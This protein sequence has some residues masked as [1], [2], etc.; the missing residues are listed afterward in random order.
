MRGNAG[1]TNDRLQRHLNNELAPT[2]HATG[3]YWRNTTQHRTVPHQRNP[4]PW[5]AGMSPQ[6]NSTPD[7]PYK[8]QPAN[9]PYNNPST[10][11]QLATNPPYGNPS[12][13]DPPPNYPPPTYMTPSGPWITTGTGQQAY[14]AGP[15][16]RLGARILDALI[17]GAVAFVVLLAGAVAAGSTGSDVLFFLTLAAVLVGLIVYEVG[18]TATKGQ[19]LGKQAVKIKVIRVDNG[20]PPGWGKSALRWVVPGLCGIIP[21]GGLICYAS[22]TWANNRQGWHD[23][24]A[25]T[26]VVKT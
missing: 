11:P 15:S 1:D 13:N 16:A 19:T 25:A 7:T 24:A 26:Y 14:L 20:Q 23:M 8:N 4:T 10:M 18:L 2:S 3:G 22:L 6:T 17:T 21:F 9:P 5:K 12:P